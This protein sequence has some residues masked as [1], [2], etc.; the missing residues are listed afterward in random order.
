MAKLLLT[1]DKDVTMERLSDALSERL[2]SKYDVFIATRESG[3]GA[4]VRKNAFMSIIVGA[5]PKKDGTE[6][7]TTYQPGSYL[8]AAPLKLMLI[9]NIL[10]FRLSRSSSRYELE[11]EVIEAIRDK[12]P[13]VTEQS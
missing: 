12:W 7:E 1:G 2:S 6:F 10:F 11:A 5:R 13:D 8:L 9:P 4:K 3:E